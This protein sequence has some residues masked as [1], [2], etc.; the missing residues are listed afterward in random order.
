MA[1]SDKPATSVSSKLHWNS[2]MDAEDTFETIMMELTTTLIEK[3]VFHCTSKRESSGRLAARPSG[4][5]VGTAPY[6]AQMAAYEK[7]LRELNDDC[8]KAI[9]TLTLLFD[10]ECNAHRL[11][12]MWYKEDVT[13][14]MSAARQRRKDYNFRNGIYLI[15]VV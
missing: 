13:A 11:L 1:S 7:S 6:V 15:M 4:A 12:K 8:N 14:G 3:S 2:P 9:G 10:P 5:G